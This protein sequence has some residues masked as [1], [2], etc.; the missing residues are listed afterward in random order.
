[1][2]ILGYPTLAPIDRAAF[3]SL[4]F[5][6]FCRSHQELLQATYGQSLLVKGLQGG[7]MTSFYLG[8]IFFELFTYVL[9]LKK[10]TCGQKL[11]TFA[12]LFFASSYIY[13]LNMLTLRFFYLNFDPLVQKLHRLVKLLNCLDNLILLSFYYKLHILLPHIKVIISCI[14][15][16]CIF[17]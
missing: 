1:M 8:Q 15:Y 4:P 7:T 11:G 12:K 3:Q 13:F 9:D 10:N 6:T 17:Q 5:V 14:L 16:V 2:A